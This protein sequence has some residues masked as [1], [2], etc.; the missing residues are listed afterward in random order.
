MLPLDNRQ[1]G[2]EIGVMDTTFSKG[3]A[4]PRGSNEL[5]KYHYFGGAG[6]SLCRRHE[7]HTKNILESDS[8]IGEHAACKVCWRKRQAFINFGDDLR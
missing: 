1:L 8:D 4:T 6:Q 5:A 2:T 3:W 7:L